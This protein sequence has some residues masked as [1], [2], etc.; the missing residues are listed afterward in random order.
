VVASFVKNLIG[1]TVQPK[2][3][4]IGGTDLG[5]GCQ[6]G[7]GEV[8]YLLGDSF[9]GGAPGSRGWWRSPIAVKSDTMGADQDIE[10]TS[11]I[12]GRSA[13][14]L[15]PNQHQGWFEGECTKIPNDVFAVGSRLYMSV[16][17]VNNW[18]NGTWETNCTLLAYSEDYGQTWQETAPQWW[19]NGPHTDVFQMQS[20]VVHEGY[21][22]VFGT[23][24]GRH[25][26]DGIYLQRVPADRVLDLSAYEGWGWTQQTGWQWGNLPTPIL[27]GCFGEPSVR[28]VEGTWVLS[29]FEPP[30]GNIVTRTAAGPDRVWSEPQLELTQQMV[31]QL[32]G[33]FI[34][35][36]STLQNLNLTISQWETQHNS[37]YH[38]MQYRTSVARAQ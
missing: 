31:P 21:A 17:S 12:G 7:N 16:M 8:L 4:S 36:N 24:N 22:Y 13:K 25:L 2:I 1:T 37:V 19:N 6:M 10:I 18:A 27:V 26:Q 20:W 23:S 30:T 15:V 3:G 34:T 35:P 11:A 28:C 5:I 32:Y 33:G 9:E 14:E 38:V 29:V